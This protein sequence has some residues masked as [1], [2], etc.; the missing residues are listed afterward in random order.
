MSRLRIL[1]IVLSV[2]GLTWLAQDA[3]AGAIRTAGKGIAKGS[4][5]VASAAASGGQAA[6][7]GVAA[8]GVATGSAV[9]TG[10]VGVAKGAKATPV[11]VGHGAKVAG[12]K[13][14]KAIW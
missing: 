8:A 10:A 1:V 12:K 5:Q 4:T 6:A 9:K 11:L 7:S 13:I 3:Q 2:C 14:A